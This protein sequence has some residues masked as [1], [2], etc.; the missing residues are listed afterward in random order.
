MAPCAAL[1]L[2]LG[3]PYAYCCAL[4]RA[5]P[6]RSVGRWCALRGAMGVHCV[7]PILWDTV[8]LYSASLVLLVVYLLRIPRLS[9]VSVQYYIVLVLSLLSFEG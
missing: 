8:C 4:T 1:G 2:S 9:L 5:L 3:L 7:L 6:V